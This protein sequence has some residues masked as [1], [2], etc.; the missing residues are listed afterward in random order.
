MHTGAKEK[1]SFDMPQGEY[2]FS[3]L[4]KAF[5]MVLFVNSEGMVEKWLA[6]SRRYGSFLSPLGKS[7]SLEDLPL[8]DPPLGKRLLHSLRKNE[9]ISF[10][11]SFPRENDQLHAQGWI[12]C[13]SSGLRVIAFQD[14]TRQNRL[15][16]KTY[17]LSQRIRNILVAVQSASMGFWEWDLESGIFSVSGN[18]GM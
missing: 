1:S 5:S 11:C 7:F 17:F 2:F 3:R 6:P 13:F 10:F 12:Y 18:G 9:E 16:R 4:G 8:E 14:R 15:A